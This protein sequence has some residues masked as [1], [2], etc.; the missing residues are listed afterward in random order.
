MLAC[1]CPFPYP[2]SLP[3]TYSGL[4]TKER[5]MG[6]E[7]PSQPCGQETVALLGLVWGG[8]CLWRDRRP[9]WAWGTFYLWV[10]SHPT[11]RKSPGGGIRSL[12]SS[13]SIWT[14]GIV[15]AYIVSLL[16]NFYKLVKWFP[17]FNPKFALS[18]G[19]LSVGKRNLRTALF[20]LPN[21]FGFLKNNQRRNWIP[22]FPLA[23]FISF[24][25]L[26]LYL[27]QPLAFNSFSSCFLPLVPPPCRPPTR[28]PAGLG[29]PSPK[30]TCILE[31]ALHLPGLYSL[32]LLLCTQTHKLNSNQCRHPW[33]P[34]V[35]REA[36]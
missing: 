28:S 2:V 3:P 14:Y 11:F 35:L 23:H 27:L 34:E 17:N 24:S 7:M 18:G 32:F 20:M 19:K 15:L 13:L 26:N 25:F 16:A 8:V 5:E 31:P 30:H 1:H 10:C 36:L 33:G 12:S 6:L 29:S 4:G 9:V 22:C 21:W